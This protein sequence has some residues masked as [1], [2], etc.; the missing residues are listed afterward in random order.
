MVPPAIP[1]VLSIHALYTGN[2]RGLVAD[3]L[4]GIE[5]GLDVQTVCTAHVVASHDRVTDSTDV[6]ADTVSSQLEHL[7]A[8]TT[9]RAA[10][11]GILGDRRTVDVVFDALDDLNGPIVLD[12]TASGPSGETVL[13]QR[14]IDALSERMSRADL[15]ML[16]RADA[17]LVTGGE[18]R[19]LDDAQVAAQRAT[20]RGAQRVLIKCGA[21]PVRFYEAADDPEAN[22]TGFHSDLYYDGDEFALFEA[23]MLD[24]GHLRGAS[25]VHSMALLR[26][27]VA[28]ASM[29][30]GLQIAK[31]EVTDWLRKSLG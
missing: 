26:V 9:P 10:K 18:I 4:A 28:G 16:R 14:G 30:E 20:N 31:R 13:T 6:P 19:S 7:F 23:P 21:L 2:R 5:Q 27:L 11:V 12:F 25:G 3:V 24:I 17:E 15:V 1:T 8:A 22:S 29:E